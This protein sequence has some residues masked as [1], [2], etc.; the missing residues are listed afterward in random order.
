MEIWIIQDFEKT[1]QNNMGS[2][3][4]ATKM[5]KC[6][7]NS[8]FRAINELKVDHVTQSSYNANTSTN[9]PMSEISPIISFHFF[10]F[11]HF[12]I[13]RDDRHHH[14]AEYVQWNNEFEQWI[15]F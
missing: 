5:A 14:S 9:W 15:V 1:I 12:P 10:L 6:I 2:M 3:N 7:R 11:F 13:Y 4:E 8:E